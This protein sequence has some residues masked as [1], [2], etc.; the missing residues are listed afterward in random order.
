MKTVARRHG[1]KISGG[2]RLVVRA[3]PSGRRFA[4]RA[5]SVEVSA[6]FA[7]AHAQSIPLWR[8]AVAPR[9]C[10]QPIAAKA[11]SLLSTPS[12][13]A[14]TTSSAASCGT[15]LSCKALRTA[16]RRQG[17]R[18]GGIWSG[19]V[20]PATRPGP[21]RARL[22]MPRD[23]IRGAAVL[24]PE[25]ARAGE[26]RDWRRPEPALPCDCDLRLSFP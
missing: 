15:L 21:I 26:W 9:G 18:S 6:G 13:Q 14:A 11:Q 19:C 5:Q 22:R 17:R 16:R 1:V 12:P 10:A 24:H 4:A 8:A 20:A 25:V 2:T 23:W 3:A 7:L